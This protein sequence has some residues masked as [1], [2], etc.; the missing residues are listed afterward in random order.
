M[1]ISE[2]FNSYSDYTVHN[3]KSYLINNK[4]E[5]NNLL[6]L[7]S[8]SNTYT[9]HNNE[10]DEIE[11]N[12]VNFSSEIINIIKKI[13]LVY[14][15]Y[16]I[17][18][19]NPDNVNYQVLLYNDLLYD[20]TS[21][22]TLMNITENFNKFPMDLFKIDRNINLTQFID[23]TDG[24]PKE[25]EEEEEKKI[26]KKMEKEM[27]IFKKVIEKYLNIN[28]DNT[29]L[30]IGNRKTLQFNTNYIFLPYNKIYNL[31][32]VKTHYRKLYESYS[33]IN[34]FKLY[35]EIYNFL[36]SKNQLLY[37]KNI[38]LIIT[39]TINNLYKYNLNKNKSQSAKSYESNLQNIQGFNEQN[40][41]EVNNTREENI[42]DIKNLKYTVHLLNLDKIIENR[43]N[44]G[45]SIE[46]YGDSSDEYSVEEYGYSDK[47]ILNIENPKS[48]VKHDISF[49]TNFVE[50]ILIP[51]ICYSFD[52]EIPGQNILIEVVLLYQQYLE[53]YYMNDQK[54]VYPFLQPEDIMY[55]KCSSNSVLEKINN[56][57]NHRV[58]V[59][60]V[61]S[62]ESR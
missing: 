58:S 6:K 23:Y 54:Y 2:Y 17:I 33:N 29:L 52:F 47:D 18:N 60:S 11:I 26:K 32:S 59:E 51:Y 28:K 12:N 20:F 53:L 34:N 46:E 15:Y 57:V 3:M 27:K 38:I 48:W 42:H 44:D 36:K 41:N 55:I 35:T 9:I 61:E 45:D 13:C 4:D 14:Y 24:Y 39:E 40:T 21:K 62:R 30:V 8:K 43:L 37:V 7:N 1:N 22:I 31:N 50:N 10:F 49:M 25:E 16:K 56:P 19:I 5:I